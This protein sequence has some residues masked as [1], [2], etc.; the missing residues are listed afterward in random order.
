[1]GGW[2][3]GQGGEWELGRGT[4]RFHGNQGACSWELEIGV[5]ILNPPLTSCLTLSKYLLSG[6]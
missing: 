3:E 6:P 5:P 4:S 1:M 2:G